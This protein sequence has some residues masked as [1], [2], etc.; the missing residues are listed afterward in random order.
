MVRP[1]VGFHMWRF[2]GQVES[3]ISVYLG[4][5]SLIYVRTVTKVTQTKVKVSTSFGDEWHRQDLVDPR[6]FILSF[7][8][9]VSIPFSGGL[10]DNYSQS[11]NHRSTGI[12]WAAKGVP[13][14]GPL[15]RGPLGS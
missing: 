12:G 8:H 2:A 5:S 13:I 1:L 15:L 6:K 14:G 4:V 9:H 7:L 3:L 11:S 10:V